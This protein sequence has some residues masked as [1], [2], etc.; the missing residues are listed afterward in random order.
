MKA[1]SIL[2]LIVFDCCITQYCF[3]KRIQIDVR[4]ICEWILTSY[5]SL[6]KSVSLLIYL[7]TSDSDQS[8]AQEYKPPISILQLILTARWSNYCVTNVSPVSPSSTSSSRME[9]Y[10]S[11]ISR[12]SG[13][14]WPV[15]CQGSEWRTSTGCRRFSSI[16]MCSRLHWSPRT[17]WQ[18]DKYKVRRMSEVWLADK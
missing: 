10:S 14:L 17:D 16:W 6:L 18:P 4:H 5:F 9:T 8:W 1:L 7:V 15:W 3:L 13:G 11:I 2:Q 12:R